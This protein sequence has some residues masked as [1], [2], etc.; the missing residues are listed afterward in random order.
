MSD[1]AVAKEAVRY[2]AGLS[3]A[4]VAAEFGAHART[5]ARGFQRFGT[6]TQGRRG[7]IH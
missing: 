3:L 4:D 2:A 5:L 7:W 6:V 1:P